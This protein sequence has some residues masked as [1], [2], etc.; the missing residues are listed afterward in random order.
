MG[1]LRPIVS[2]QIVCVGIIYL[3]IVVVVTTRVSAVEF[4]L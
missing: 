1:I 2:S 3:D 4:G